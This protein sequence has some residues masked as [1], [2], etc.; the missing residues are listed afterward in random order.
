VDDLS[1][2]E[3]EIRHDVDAGADIIVTGADYSI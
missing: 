3:R 2:A 1:K